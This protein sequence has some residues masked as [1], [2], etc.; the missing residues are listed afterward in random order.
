MS[1]GN[2]YAITIKAYLINNR[3]NLDS[4]NL[5]INL[6]TGKI[7]QYRGTYYLEIA[8]TDKNSETE[9]VS[10]AWFVTLPMSIGRD[11]NDNVMF[12]VDHKKN[13]I[14]PDSIFA[15]MKVFSDSLKNAGNGK[16]N[17]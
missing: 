16:M 9:K 7:T 11:D 4:L 3:F 17:R 14:P 2:R 5:S 13:I 15:K 8:Y 1:D 12:M 6:F 10:G